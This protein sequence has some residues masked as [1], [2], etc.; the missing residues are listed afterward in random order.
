MWYVTNQQAVDLYYLKEIK[1]GSVYLGKN[2][3]YYVDILITINNSRF[4]VET[5]PCMK[6]PAGTVAEENELQQAADTAFMH[7]TGWL[8]EQESESNKPFI[9]WRDFLQDFE[10]LHQLRELAELCLAEPR[11]S[12]F[13]AYNQDEG[14]D[15]WSQEDEDD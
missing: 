14:E 4:V 15:W 6:V 9:S 13:F 3:T 2:N 10:G 1:K 5:V 7:F 12:L 11:S 8:L